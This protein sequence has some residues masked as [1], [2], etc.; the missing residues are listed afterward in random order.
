MQDNCP[1]LPNS[2]QEDSDTDGIGDACDD[3]ADNDGI[4]NKDVRQSR[5]NNG[6]LAKVSF[7]LQDNCPYTSNIRQEDSDRRSG[8]G[9]RYGNACDNCPTV[10]NP[11]QVDA[12]GDGIGD[13][14]DEDADNDGIPNA[15]DNCP[16]VVNSEQS[17]V[18][19]DG[20]GDKCD[21]CPRMANSDQADSDKDFVGDACDT[22]T[23]R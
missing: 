6:S 18:D 17:D 13:A 5:F 12:D 2:G 19:R 21:N 14:C 15:L 20:V 9:D 11:N 10:Y 1:N 23:D 8:G 3:D 16:L 7:P 4:P 22:G